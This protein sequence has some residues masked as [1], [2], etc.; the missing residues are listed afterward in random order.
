MKIKTLIKKLKKI[1]DAHGNIDVS[2]HDRGP[3]DDQENPR[4]ICLIKFYDPED[5]R[6]NKSKCVADHLMICGAETAQ[7]LG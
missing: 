7:E 1:E 3:E 4:A 5:S 6:N 2:V